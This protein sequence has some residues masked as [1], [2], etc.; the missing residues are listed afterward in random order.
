MVASALV[1]TT[2]TPSHA[3]GAGCSRCTLVFGIGFGLVNAP[4]TTRPCPGMP[5]NQAGVAAAIASTSRQVGPALGVAVVGSILGT[6]VG[7]GLGTQLASAS[8]P[9][10]WLIS[11][12]G[13]S[14]LVLGVATT[15]RWAQRTARLTAQRLEQEAAPAP[16]QP[17]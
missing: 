5:N 11:G 8:H 3:A 13:A 16:L 14:V 15:G 4:I 1:L 2:L 10:W 17:A 7:D 6:A 12:C 9:A